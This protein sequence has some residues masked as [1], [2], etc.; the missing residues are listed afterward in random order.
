M[1]YALLLLIILNYFSCTHLVIVALFIRIT[2]M[3]PN[4]DAV[5]GIPSFKVNYL[6]M[7]ILDYQTI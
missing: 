6:V 2:L 5:Y 3:I 4:A 1:I 7:Y